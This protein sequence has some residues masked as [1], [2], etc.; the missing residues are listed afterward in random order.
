MG[1]EEEKEEVEEAALYRAPN[2]LFLH[3]M[4]ELVH[5]CVCVCVCVYARVSVFLCVYAYVCIYMCVI[6]KYLS[7]SC[8]LSLP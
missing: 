7:S 2:F 6:L 4:V 1:E 5:V 8:P 3:H